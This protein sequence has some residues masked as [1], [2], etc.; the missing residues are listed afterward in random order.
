MPYVD[1]VPKVIYIGMNCKEQNRNKLITIAKS[2][3][4]PVYQMSLYEF[5]K[6]TNWRR[7]YSKYDR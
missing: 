7:N 2:L 5:S 3:S 4:I 6:N 1:A